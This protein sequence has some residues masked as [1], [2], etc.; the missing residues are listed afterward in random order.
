MEPAD[1]LLNEFGDKC[2]KPDSRRIQTEPGC[3]GSEK[4][5]DSRQ[6]WL[7]GHL[8]ASQDIRPLESHN[9]APST[10]RPFAVRSG[11]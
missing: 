7:S 1:A 6:S 4:N 5:R 11:L 9:P 10:L 2:N 3:S 8:P